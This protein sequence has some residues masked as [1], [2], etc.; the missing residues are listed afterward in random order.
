MM[1]RYLSILMIL[2]M[3]ALS[4]CSDTAAQPD[5]T[6]PQEPAETEA[7][8]AENEDVRVL[9]AY[10]T[11]AENADLPEDVDASTSASIQPGDALTGNTGLVAAMI[12]DELDADLFSIQTQERYPDTYDETIAQGQQEQQE[13]ARPALRSQVEDMASYDVVFLG[14][15]NWWG[16]M[17]MAV[18]SFLDEYDLS[19]K[20]I[21][22]FVTSGGSGFSNTV[23]AIAQLEPQAQIIEGLALSDSEAPQAQTRVQEWLGTLEL[24]AG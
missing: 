18:Y 5:D 11:Y 17:P 22:P 7:A 20:Q 1:R 19:G 6:Q 15:P 23:A 2:M 14:Y 8:P 10:F 16:D 4:A 9:V 13:A 21:I 12:A 3:G 24:S